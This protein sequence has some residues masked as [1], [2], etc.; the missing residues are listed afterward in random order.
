MHKTNC[1]NCGAPLNAH[2]NCDYCGTKAQAECTSSIELSA[3]KIVMTCSGINI[4]NS[5]VCPDYERRLDHA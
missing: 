1:K 4:Q 3:D 2:G 5:F